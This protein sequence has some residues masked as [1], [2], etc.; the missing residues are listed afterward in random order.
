MIE[1]EPCV[2]WLKNSASL[3]NSNKRLTR[4]IVS[5]FKSE[6]SGTTAVEFALLALPFFYI[7]LSIIG[8]GFYLFTNV[9]L[10]SAAE[11]AARDVRTGQ[12]QSAGETLT[13]FKTKLC[14]AAG[15]SI[16]CGKVRVHVQSSSDWKDLTPPSCSKT[17]GG[18]EVLSTGTSETDGDGNPVTLESQ[19]GSA[20][21][22]F[23]LTLCYE[24][25][26]AQ[27]LPFPS[28]NNER[29]EQWVRC[30][31]IRKQHSGSSLT[32][33]EPNRDCRSKRT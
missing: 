28:T 5:R 16:D 24:F 11:T 20:G 33:I 14:D 10:D 13:N 22:V 9:A 32:Q 1:C 17:E 3:K 2:L 30:N 31:P 12:S 15:G 8:Y 25:E 6:T 23:L 27:I 26:M 4:D 19:A 7:I 29:F 18:S 21:D